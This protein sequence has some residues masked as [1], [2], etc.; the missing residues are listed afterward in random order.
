MNDTEAGRARP[1]YRAHWHVLFVHFPISFFGVAFGFQTLHLFF[2]PACFTL[3]STVVL[4]AGALMMVPTTVSGW[5]SW[6]HNY[7]GTRTHVSTRKIVTATPM[8]VTSA[9]LVGWRLTFYSIF[10]EEPGAA[11]WIYMAGSSL[12][13]LG[14]VVE[15]YYGGRLHHSN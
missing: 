13:I 7:K 10:A 6:K 12:L 9:A 5:L 14:A 1:R 4:I 15:G 8:L 3:S 2:A 11:H